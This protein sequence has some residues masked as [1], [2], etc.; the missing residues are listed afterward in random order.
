MNTQRLSQTFDMLEDLAR[1]GVIR[2]TINKPPK[3]HA[4]CTL[5]GVFALVPRVSYRGFNTADSLWTV[6][7]KHGGM[8]CGNGLG[9]TKDKKYYW[10][11]GQA[12]ENFHTGE[13]TWIGQETNNYRKWYNEE[14]VNQLFDIKQE[15]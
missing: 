4:K 11:Q 1:N 6:L 7:H 9:E 5:P 3:E 10:V 14:I 8:Y 15:R 12:K 2:V 13:Y